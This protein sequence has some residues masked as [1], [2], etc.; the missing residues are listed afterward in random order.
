L[1]GKTLKLYEGHA[2]DL[3]AEVGK[4][5]VAGDITAWIDTQLASR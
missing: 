5:A 2:H 4:A 1:A 3:L